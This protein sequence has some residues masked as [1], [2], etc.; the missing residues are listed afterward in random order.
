MPLP[1]GNEGN[2]N[3]T[4]EVTVVAAPASTKQRA[5]PTSGLS[6]YNADT[7]AADIIVQKNKN[8]TRTI[9]YKKTALASGASD[10][11]LVKVVLDAT[12]ESLE[13]KLGGAITTTQP[14]YNVAYVEYP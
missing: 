11:M 13:V 9:V 3:S 4:T 10:V 7:V 8:G 1:I 6:V 14:T 2:F 12:D 5:I